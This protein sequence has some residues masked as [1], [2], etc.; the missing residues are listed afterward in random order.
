M[1]MFSAMLRA[2]DIVS[3]IILVIMMMILGNTIAMGVRER[4][5]EYGVLRAVGFLPRH[6]ATFIVGES[7]A[8]GLVGGVL[9]IAISYPI[10]ELGIGRFLEENMGSFFPYFRV[11]PKVAGAALLLSGLLGAAAAI[12]PARG[13]ARLSVIDSLRRVE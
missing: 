9:G 4:T 13:A 5:G 6:I 8:L 3:I 12:L 1:A 10:V 7:I 2:L 11:D